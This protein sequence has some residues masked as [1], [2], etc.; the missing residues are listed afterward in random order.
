MI[1]IGV[2][3]HKR[4]HAAV[5]VDAA[6]RELGRWRGPN[7]AAG[8]EELAEWAAALGGACRWGIEG[9]W[10]Y[11]R[12]LAQHLV[13]A[14]ATVYEVNARWTAAGRR[15]GRRAGKSDALDALAVARCVCREAP[16][17]PPVAAD[18]E[19]AVL[20]LLATQRQ[21][22]V[23]EATRLRCQLHQLLALLDPEYAA[24]LPKLHTEA[25][26]R[27]L[28]AYEAADPRPLSGSAP[29]QSA[30]WHSAC[31]WRSPR[32]RNW[33][34]RSGHWRRSTPR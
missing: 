11:G 10:N 26:L 17:L 28:E 13:E 3:A 25:G 24:R 34:G 20:D 4:V 27:A 30:G 33:P 19:T 12:R 21:D 1:T 8:W 7:T 18:D 9:A 2:D 29:R 23:A 32:P 31:G 22:A 5:A 6:G 14:G 15:Q 16:G